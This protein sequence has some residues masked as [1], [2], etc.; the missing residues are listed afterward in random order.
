M[1]C[2]LRVVRQVR[3]ARGGMLFHRCRIRGH[4]TQELLQIALG[5]A[6]SLRPPSNLTPRRGIRYTFGRDSCMFQVTIRTLRNVC[7]RGGDACGSDVDAGLFPSV[8][9]WAESGPC[10]KSACRR[11]NRAVQSVTM[12]AKSLH[13]GGAKGRAWSRCASLWR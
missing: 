7:C 8:D 11:V 5:R 13:V 3:K 2:M 10:G 12:S 4:L 6:C 1:V 9:R